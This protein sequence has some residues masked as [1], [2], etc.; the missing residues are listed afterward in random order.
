MVA[1]YFLNIASPYL[2]LSLLEFIAVT[3]LILLV[4]VLVSIN[5]GNK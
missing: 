3:V 4:L 5:R 2:G 1:N